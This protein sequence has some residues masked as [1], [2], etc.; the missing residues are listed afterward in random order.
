MK[1]NI[2]IPSA[3]EMRETT[4]EARLREVV[5]KIKIAAERGYDY[6]ELGRL[7]FEVTKLL[8][9]RGYIVYCFGQPSPETKIIWGERNEL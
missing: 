3:Q 7:D 4:F 2:N 9:E 5:E 6:A 8:E 1:I